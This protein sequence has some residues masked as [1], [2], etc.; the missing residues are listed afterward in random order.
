MIFVMPQ[1]YDFVIIRLLLDGVHT[2]LLKKFDI[3]LKVQAEL[4]NVPPLPN[5]QFS[6][7]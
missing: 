7:L 6:Q 4:L 2:V 5:F 3:L 1:A